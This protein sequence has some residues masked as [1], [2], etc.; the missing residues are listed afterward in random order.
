[1]FTFNTNNQVIHVGFNHLHERLGA[2][3]DVLM[4]KDISLLVEDADIEAAGMQVD[5]A[6]MFMCLGV[7][8]HRG[9]LLRCS[10]NDTS[11]MVGYASQA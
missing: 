2:G 8:F 11:R 10:A 1:M 9:L 5:T 6:V 7:E 3:F 4:D